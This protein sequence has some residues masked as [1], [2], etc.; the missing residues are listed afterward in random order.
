MDGLTAIVVI[1]CIL[2]LPPI[3]GETINDIIDKYYMKKREL[4]HFYF[5]QL[6]N[7]IEELNIIEEK[8]R[9]DDE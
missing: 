8:I 6:R 9:G 3:I 4:I 2:L 5:T 1:G 7:F